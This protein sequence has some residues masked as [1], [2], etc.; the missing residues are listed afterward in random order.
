M[1]WD[2]GVL[3]LVVV[4]PSILEKESFS[5]ISYTQNWRL[6]TSENGINTVCIHTTT[7]TIQNTVM[8]ITISSTQ[9]ENFKEKI[10]DK[11]Q[12]FLYRNSNSYQVS[13]WTE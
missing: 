9:K 8:T 11:E 7:T 13:L 10:T 3:V 2:S 12:P 6:N 5:F 4:W 1:R